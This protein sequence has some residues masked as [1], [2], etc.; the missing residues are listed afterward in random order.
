M[1]EN[2]KY[3]V[4]NTITDTFKLH[5]CSILLK[6]SLTVIGYLHLHVWLHPLKKKKLNFEGKIRKMDVIFFFFIKNPR[7]QSEIPGPF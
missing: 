1:F 4:V 7:R 5:K 2:T 3:S 6:R